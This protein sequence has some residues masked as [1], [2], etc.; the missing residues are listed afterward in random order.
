MEPP[1]VSSEMVGETGEQFRATQIARQ[2]KKRAAFRKT[3]CWN[4]D[5]AG[6]TA[7]SVQRAS[8]ARASE[9]MYV[10]RYTRQRSTLLLQAGTYLQLLLPVVPAFF[11]RF[12]PCVVVRR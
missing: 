2:K 7:R 12:R 10:C 6:S 5:E 8:T 11:P 4:S 1:D 9:I 3:G